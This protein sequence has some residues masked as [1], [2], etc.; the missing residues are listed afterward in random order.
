MQVKDIM[1]KGADCVAPDCSVQAAARKMKRHNIGALPVCDKSMLT[2]VIT[3][4]DIV[5]R[6]VSEGRDLAKTKVSEIMTAKPAC[7]RQ[8]AD[9]QTVARLMEEMKI[10]RIPVLNRNEKLVGM[11]SVDDFTRRGPGQDLLAEILE[12]AAARHV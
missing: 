2:G 4:R 9:I 8:D 10:R 3:D 11:L 1:H 5:V 6:G 7:C 12:S